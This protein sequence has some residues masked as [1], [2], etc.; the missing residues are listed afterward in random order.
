MP[1]T[2]RMVLDRTVPPQIYEPT[3]DGTPRYS[4]LSSEEVNSIIERLTHRDLGACCSE[5]KHRTIWCASWDAG[6]DLIKQ[7]GLYSAAE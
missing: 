4:S 5:A 2:S 1:V 6:T 3:W 7:V